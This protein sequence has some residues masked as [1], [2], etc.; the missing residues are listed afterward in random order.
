VKVTIWKFPIEI[1]DEQQVRMPVGAYIL[2][3]G[4]DPH[5]D[6]CVWAQVD[7]AEKHKE[8]RRILIMGTGNL[9]EE[10]TASFLASVTMPP[11]VWHV[12]ND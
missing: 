1:A 7:P 5:G 9:F 10:T 12:Y 4:I 6:L 2:S 11:F 8:D 3:A